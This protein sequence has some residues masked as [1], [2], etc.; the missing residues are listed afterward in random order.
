MQTTK[1]SLVLA[2]FILAFSIP[3]ASAPQAGSS[4]PAP[5]V[6]TGE[7]IGN[8]IKAAI[9]TAVPGVSSILDLIWSKRAN[10]VA[11]KEKKTEAQQK[12]DLSA[13]AQNPDVQKK[14]QA[15][16]VAAAQ[17]RIQPI[18]KVSAELAVLN[19]FLEPSVEASGRLIAIR[20]QLKDS[21]VPWSDVKTNFELAKQ[22]LQ[23]LKTVSDTDLNSIRD[24]YLRDKLKHIRDANDAPTLLIDSDI[25]AKNAEGLGGDA[26]A[27]ANTLA[28]MTAMAGYELADLQSDI[29]EL[30]NWAKGT[31]GGAVPADQKAYKGFL[32]EHVR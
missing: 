21:P 15:D 19:R 32:D 6:A 28:D 27:L 25:T 1:T 4:T 26:A 29:T 7:K 14:V 2:C 20:T 18:G 5:G 16:F 3:L 13:G 24:L 8:V 10:P 17:Q 30:A 31:G 22:Q 23:K 9:T 11:D 12:S